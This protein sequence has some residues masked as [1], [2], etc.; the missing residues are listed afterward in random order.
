LAGWHAQ[1]G[2]MEAT[3]VEKYDG[4]KINRRRRWITGINIVTVVTLT[5]GILLIVWYV[6]INAI[7]NS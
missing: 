3:N 1:K 5:G 7:L 4:N 6:V 2:A